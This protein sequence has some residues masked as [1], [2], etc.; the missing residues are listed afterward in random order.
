MAAHLHDS[1]LQTLA[2]IQRKADQPRELVALARRQER[3]LRAWLYGSTNGSTGT[4]SRSI[5]AMATEVE[6]VHGVDVDVVTV[7]DVALD[8][9]TEALVQAAREAVVNAA[10]HS[11]A[12]AVSVYVETDGERVTAFIRDRGRGFDV[13]AVPDDRKGITSSIRDR[14]TRHGGTATVT[15]SADD[16][17]EVDPGVGRQVSAAAGPRVFLVD[18]HGLFLSGVRAELDGVVDVVGTATEVGEAI[19]CDSSGR[20]R[21]RARRRAHA[22]R[23][24]EGDHRG[25]APGRAGRALPR[26]L[27]LRRRGGR[28]RGDP[29]RGS[30]VRD[31]DDRAGRAGGRGPARPRRRRS[32]LAPLGRIRPRRVRRRAGL[33]HHRARSGA[34]QVDRARSATSSASLHAATRTRRSRAGSRSR[35]RRSRRTCP[36]C[37]RKLQLST[38]HELT[39]WASDR[40]VV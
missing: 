30:R 14:M 24:R 18:D 21:R 34:R 6:E 3:E 25:R 4:L 33:G 5:E 8:P 40:G 11:G 29:G 10:K 9:S 20:A 23:W 1:V 36:R 28:D 39:R 35:S 12:T 13:S 7:G 37:L 27:G 22:R 16:G 2:L 38:R 26:P 19:D 17:T 15:S 32:V 31:Q